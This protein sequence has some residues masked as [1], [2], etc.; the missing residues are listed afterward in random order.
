L[1]TGTG[2]SLRDDPI[3]ARISDQ[4]IQ[5]APYPARLGVVAPPNMVILAGCPTLLVAQLAAS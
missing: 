1:D 5:D 2:D 3:S 4:N